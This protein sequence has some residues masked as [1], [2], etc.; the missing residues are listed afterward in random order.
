MR[1]GSSCPHSRGSLSSGIAT[2][3]QYPAG[4]GAQYLVLPHRDR[5][6]KNARLTIACQGNLATDGYY[7]ASSGVE[8][9]YPRPWRPAC[10][11]KVIRADNYVLRGLTSGLPSCA[12]V[13]CPRQHQKPRLPPAPPRQRHVQRPSDAV[14]VGVV[15]VPYHGGDLQSRGLPPAPAQTPEYPGGELRRAVHQHRCSVMTSS[16]TSQTSG[17]TRSTTRFALFILWE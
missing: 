4:V 12:S 9:T 14:K 1:S 7:G 16:S 5:L 8:N 3:E 2:F 13:C 11:S 15:A 10:L 17:R 6:G